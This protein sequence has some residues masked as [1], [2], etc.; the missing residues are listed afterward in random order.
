MSDADRRLAQVCHELQVDPEVLELTSAP[1]LDLV[2][3]VAHGVSR[4]A[5][6]L[7]VFLIGLAVGAGASG[8]HPQRTVEEV[9]AAVERLRLL[10]QEWTP[11]PQP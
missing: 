11:Q 3:E 4:P 8:T 2:R 10:V 5:G 1:L 6:P 9:A 7:T